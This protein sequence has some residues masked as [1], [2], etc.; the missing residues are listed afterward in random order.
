[1]MKCTKCEGDLGCKKVRVVRA[2]RNS[3]KSFA[4]ENFAYLRHNEEKL[5]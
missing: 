1:M 3:S 5:C 4:D 2:R